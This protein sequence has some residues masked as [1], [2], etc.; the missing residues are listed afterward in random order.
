MT[1]A[2]YLALAVPLLAVLAAAG[3]ERGRD[4]RAAA[5]LAFVVSMIGIAALN[6]AARLAGWFAF[7]PVGGA[8]RGMPVDLWIGWAALW[9][10]LP[11]LLRRVLPLPLTLGLLLW[12]DAVA[13]PALTPL[14]RLGPHWLVGE[15]VGLIAVALPAQLLG[16]FSADR[17]HLRTRT[18]LQVGLFSAMLL[19]FLPTLAFELGGGSWARLSAMPMPLLLL[20]AQVGLLVAAP[21]L[22]AVREFAARGGGT[23]YPWD[24]PR[25][26]VTTGPYAYLANPM[27]LG[28]VTLVLV[29]AAATRSPALVAVAVTAVAFSAAVARPHEEHDLAR[30]YGLRWRDYRRQVHDWW[31]RWR[32]YATGA[33][34]VLWLDDDCGPCAAVWRFL[35]RRAPVNLTIAPAAEHPQVLWRAGYAGGDGHTDRGVAAVARALEHVNLGWA[36]VGW[37]LRLPGITW[38]AQLVS[39]AMIAPPHPASRRG[40]RCPTPSNGCSTGRSPRSASTA[41]PVCRPVPSPRP[42]G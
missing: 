15:A 9:G 25:R 7:A 2:R 26:L 17:R 27:Q 29:V 3:F 18:L 31:P 36:L 41:S 33:S 21:A 24:P 42:P 19:W 35:D 16:R 22:A 11:V 4:A 8:W 14:V 38:L 10:P 30:R 12:L 23:P 40:E 13:M 28:A 39:D 5:L 34:A 20:V 1:A 6:D 32:P 37:T